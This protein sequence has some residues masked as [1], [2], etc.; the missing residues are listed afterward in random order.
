MNIVK[1]YVGKGKRKTTIGMEREQ[2]TSEYEKAI[3]FI[4]KGLAINTNPIYV[5]LLHIYL[6]YCNNLDHKKFTRNLSNYYT[7]NKH[8]FHSLTKEYFLNNLITQYLKLGF[9]TNLND[10]LYE[11]YILRLH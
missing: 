2:T 10:Y 1:K 8:L 7:Q 3:Q 4:N 11:L 5:T 6:N 9:I